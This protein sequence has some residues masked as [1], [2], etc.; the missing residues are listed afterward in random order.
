MKNLFPE[1]SK[2][3]GEVLATFGQ[4]RLIKKL[5]GKYE[6]RGGSKEDLVAA[7]EWI[8]MFMDDKAVV[9]ER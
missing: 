9:R 1:M 6:L 3:D 7:R 5:D 4:A 2:S 8:S